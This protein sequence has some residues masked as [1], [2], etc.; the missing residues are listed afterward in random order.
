MNSSSNGREK[1]N[2]EKF[3]Y[4]ESGKKMYTE[5]DTTFGLFE[6]MFIIVFILVIGSFVVMAV[7]GLS[8]WNKNNNSP[9]LA[10]SAVVV[11]KRSDV[12]YHHHANVNQTAHFDSTTTYYV[13][14]QVESGDRMEFSVSGREYGMLVE[15]DQ[16]TLSFQGT[17][18]LSF[19]REGQQEA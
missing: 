2:R 14:F 3:I 5:F 10:V 15:G 12:S 16:G 9:R 13:T 8:T 17:R 18:Y 4:T 1:G 7:K 6:S 19:Q 11:T